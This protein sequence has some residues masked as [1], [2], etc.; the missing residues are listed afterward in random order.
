M[1][2]DTEE[3]ARSQ[4]LRFIEGGNHA[5]ARDVLVEAVHE[6]GQVRLASLLGDVADDLDEPELAESAYR[7]AMAAGDEQARNDYGVFLRG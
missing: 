5:A 1:S 3:A 7:T 2:E 4:A 6:R